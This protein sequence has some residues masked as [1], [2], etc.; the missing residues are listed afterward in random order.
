MRN[1][2]RPS[3][4]E[5]IVPT[6]RQLEMEILESPPCR[7]LI[8]RSPPNWTAVIFFATL[9]LLHTCICVPAFFHGRWEGYMSLTFACL[10]TAVSIASVRFV[11]E[12]VVLPIQKQ[13][14]VSI[15]VGWFKYERQFPFS[16]I[17]GVRLTLYSDRPHGE[18]R[19]ELLCPGD[20]VQCPPTRVP[21]EEALCL[22]MTMNVPLIKTFPDGVSP[23]ATTPRRFDD[24]S[25]N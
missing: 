7:D 12:L 17:R 5:R 1:S 8:F 21:R 16:S 19:I 4:D 20:D 13:V 14:R 22:A 6:A 18:S 11:T 3:Y 10:F 2:S 24:V 25:L 15:G 23:T 9:A